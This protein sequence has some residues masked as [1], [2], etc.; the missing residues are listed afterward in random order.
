[1]A[2]KGI[3]VRYGDVKG[4]SEGLIFEEMLDEPVD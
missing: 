2:E 4:F 3:G 1:M